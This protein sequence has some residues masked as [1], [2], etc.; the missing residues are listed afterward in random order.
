M[1]AFKQLTKI[2]RKKLTF[3][4]LLLTVIVFIEIGT[5]IQGFFPLVNPI[6]CVY[7]LAVTT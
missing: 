2:Y 1:H 4:I 6:F 7:I 3:F 5:I